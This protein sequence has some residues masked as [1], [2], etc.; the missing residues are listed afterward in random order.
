VKY[1]H[2]A[3]AIAT[4]LGDEVVALQLETKRYYTLNATAACTWRSLAR[5]GDEVTV[6]EALAREFDIALGDT[7]P[8]AAAIT[9][10]LLR[11]RLIEPC[12]SDTESS[13]T[14]PA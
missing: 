11:L 5:G 4:E 8:H 14:S 3:S 9:R 6:G 2:S 12:A 13:P 7:P 1:R 10:E